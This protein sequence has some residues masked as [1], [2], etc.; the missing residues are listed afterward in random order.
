MKRSIWILGLIVLLP[1]F[2]SCEKEVPG[3]IREGNN[4]VINQYKQWNTSK[5]PA[6]IGDISAFPK[7]LQ[8]VIRQR[9][10][11]QVSML[12]PQNRRA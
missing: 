1:L 6:Y 5:Q 4:I 8:A 3:T 9:F 12:L 10:P 2:E 7:D 11:K